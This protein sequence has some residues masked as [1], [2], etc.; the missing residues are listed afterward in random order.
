MDSAVAPTL[1][2]KAYPEDYPVSRPV[3]VYPISN[4]CACSGALAIIHY[5]D[6]LMPVVHASKGCTFVFKFPVPICGGNQGAP[7]YGGYWTPCTNL[8]EK[9]IIM[10]GEE[11]LYQTL[12]PIPEIYEG[13]EG[14]YVVTGCTADIIGDDIERVIRRAKPNLN[15]IETMLFSET[16]GFKG[17]SSDG[18]NIVLNKICREVVEPPKAKLKN[19]INIMGIWPHFKP[20]WLGEIEE[21]KRILELLEINVH[22]ILPGECN[23]KGIKTM[24]EA[25]LNVVVSDHIGIEAADILQEKYGVPYVALKKGTPIG[26]EATKEFFMEIAQNLSLDIDKVEK[27]LEDEENKFYQSLQ[28]VAELWAVITSQTYGIIGDSDYVMGMVR[29]LTQVLGFYPAIVAMTSYGKDTEKN[30]D[31]LLKELVQWREP[32]PGGEIPVLWDPNLPELQKALD[33]VKPNMIIGR[34][35]DREYAQ[36]IG[37]AS[38]VAFYPIIERFILNRSYSGYKGA[39]TLTEDILSA[40]GSG[41]WSTSGG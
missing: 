19:T 29:F 39:L 41:Y 10:G 37:K 32:S 11:K 14:I 23:L 35:V 21:L 30:F 28:K 20:F 3:L 38:L 34:S 40:P 22:V 12:L 25:S 6:G 36:R 17:R 27:K 7:R 8:I 13:V 15:G 16:G 4:I 1:K 31:N 18:S 26:A 2:D 5:I 9:D 33:Q 24:A